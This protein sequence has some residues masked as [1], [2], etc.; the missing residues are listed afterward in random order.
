MIS[1]TYKKGKSAEKNTQG[2]LWQKFKGTFVASPQ[3]LSSIPHRVT[4]EKDG[5]HRTLNSVT[6]ASA[7][8]VF[9]SSKKRNV[10]KKEKG[11]QVVSTQVKV[12]AAVAAA[13]GLLGTVFLVKQGGFLEGNPQPEKMTFFS[14]E[15][16]TQSFSASMHKVLS[17][18]FS[19]FL[20][21]GFALLAL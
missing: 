19:S 21:L 11:A 13:L 3:K 6:A 7:Q 8:K 16:S 5:K 2:S 15:E 1:D 10:P 18:V 12:M 4:A 20:P 14:S 9:S 17:V